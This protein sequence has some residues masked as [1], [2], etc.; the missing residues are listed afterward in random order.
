MIESLPFALD[1]GKCRRPGAARLSAAGLGLW[2][3]LAFLAL[4]LAGAVT[5]AAS[6]AP[7]AGLCGAAIAA[8]EPGTQLP[9]HLLS[10]IGVVESGRADPGG[11]VTPWP[12]TINIGGVDH[13]FETQ[14][15]AVAA[16]QAAQ[17]AGVQSI[18]VGCMQVNLFYHPHAFA[19]LEEAFDPA[20]N[21]RYAS[22]FLEALHAQ[23]GEWAA[24]IAAYHS[25]TPELGAAYLQRVAAR[26]PLAARF[27]LALW[28][29][30][31][32]TAASLEME[33][34]PNH[35]LTPEFR[36]QLVQAAAFRHEREA[37]QPDPLPFAAVMRAPAPLGWKAKDR[38]RASGIA[39]LEAEV[40]PR[41][42][43]T[44]EFRAQLV[45]AAAFRHQQEAARGGLAVPG[46]TSAASGTGRFW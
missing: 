16:V 18:D 17:Q 6:A 32:T 25:S 46:G 44:E 42:V 8:T 35:V 19:S 31:R 40:D 41:H 7:D 3:S 22:R 28:A 9:P 2:P 29:E 14:A 5:H 10:A 24:A 30:T 43:L 26:W 11:G 12:W 27:G 33:V 45:A 4:M 23:T 1:R 20:A 13:I 39:A 15:A 21:V 36:A 38:A 34:D 37:Q